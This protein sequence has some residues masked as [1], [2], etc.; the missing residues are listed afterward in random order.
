MEGTS[1]W[2]GRRCQLRVESLLSSSQQL[3]LAQCFES[4]PIKG[5]FGFSKSLV[6]ISNWVVEFAKGSV[7]RFQSFIA[8]RYA[9]FGR[10]FGCTF[11]H[12]D[13]EGYEGCHGWTTQARGNSLLIVGHLSVLVS[14]AVAIRPR[15][16]I[17]CLRSVLCSLGPYKQPPS[18]CEFMSEFRRLDLTSDFNSFLI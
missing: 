7:A 15:T 10:R 3:G 12:F 14:S 2:A 9:S 18:W 17:L 8:G 13:G 5:S 6:F 11:K 1:F 4:R 16:W